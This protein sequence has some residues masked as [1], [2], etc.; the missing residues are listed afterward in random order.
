VR[1]LGGLRKVGCGAEGCIADAVDEDI[2][3]FTYYNLGIISRYP[4]RLRCTMNFFRPFKHF[5]KSLGGC[6][7]DGDRLS[8]TSQLNHCLFPCVESVSWLTITKLSSSFPSA[9]SVFGVLS[10]RSH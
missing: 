2:V 7:S 6:T 1:E 9:L 8:A 5:R 10:H 4:E 3:H